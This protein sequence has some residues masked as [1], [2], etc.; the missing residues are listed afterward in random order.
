MIPSS[1]A[2]SDA[3]GIRT[4]W[5]QS[6]CAIDPSPSVGVTPRD[7]FTPN[8]A[9]FKRLVLASNGDVVSGRTSS[10]TAI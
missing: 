7:R 1:P 10:S 5:A 9:S 2:S 4:C 8:G 3:R 6:S